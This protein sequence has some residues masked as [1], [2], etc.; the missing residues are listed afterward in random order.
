MDELRLHVSTRIGLKKGMLKVD[1]YVQY[2]SIY[3]KFL[4]IYTYLC[5]NSIKNMNRDAKFQI[6]ESEYFLDKRK[7][8]RRGQTY[9]ELKRYLICFIILKNSETNKAKY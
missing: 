5:R 4:C 3:M 2:D 6:S 9:Q 1:T 7:K 8:L